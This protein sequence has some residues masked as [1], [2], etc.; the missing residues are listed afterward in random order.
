MTL[1]R[2]VRARLART[3]R[4]LLG[5]VT[6][7]R[8]ESSIEGYVIRLFCV[9]MIVVVLPVLKLVQLGVIGFLLALVKVALAGLLV[10]VALGI[11]YLVQAWYRRRS[12]G[13]AQA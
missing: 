3:G 9:G 1:G 11:I 13:K 4:D 5:L 10:T 12:L 7:K 8:H 2:V 6:L